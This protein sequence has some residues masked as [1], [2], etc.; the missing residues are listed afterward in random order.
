MKNESTGKILGISL[1]V[2]LICAILVSTTAVTLKPVQRQ[3]QENDRL[4]NILNVAGLLAEGTTD[5][6]S[7]YQSSIRPVVID[8]KTGNPIPEADC[9]DAFRPD[10]FDIKAL[11]GNPEYTVPLEHDPAQIKRQP[12]LMIMY[13]VME[14][15]TVSAIILPMYGKGLWSTMYAFIALDADHNRLRLGFIRN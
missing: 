5:Y 2:C 1:G 7:L 14:S 10:R 15:D 3:N 4:R 9:P 12:T 8:L 11:S 13:K 6:Q